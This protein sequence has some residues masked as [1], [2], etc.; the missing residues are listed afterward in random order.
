MVLLLL[1]LLVL[2]VGSG[3]W[4]LALGLRMPSVML[5]GWLVVFIAQTSVVTLVMGA[6]EHLSSGWL[7]VA[8]LVVALV[9]VG[10]A[11]GWRRAF[12]S[13]SAVS[14]GSG[15]RS[16]F[17]HSWRH[18]L[19]LIF[20]CTVLVAY[21][22][23]LYLGV[24][25]P[26]Y[27]YDANAYHLVS[28]D[29]WVMTGRLVDTPQNLYS[30]VY[31]KGQELLEA[32][33]AVFLRTMQYAVLAQ[34]FLV[35]LG[36]TSVFLLSRLVRARRSYAAMAA[37][38]FAAIPVVFLQ[39]GTEYVDV[40]A[41][42]TA[43]A[44]I[45]LVLAGYTLVRMN[46]D[47]P[48]AAIPERTYHGFVACLLLAGISA[49]MAASIKSS[50]LATD[51][52]ALLVALTCYWRL[53]NRREMPDIPYYLVSI[54]AL[55]AVPML[56]IASFWYF[57]TW[58]GYGSP[59]YPV[60]V[61][62]LPG[63]GT[64]NDI[65]IGGNL[66]DSLAHEPGGK[67]GQI[68]ASWATDLHRH[69]YSYDQRLGGFGIQWPVILLPALVV[70]GVAWL[71]R[72]DRLVWFGI[73]FTSLVILLVVG[74]GWWS[75]YTIFLPA[76][77]CAALA[78]VLERLARLR[79]PWRLAPTVI[80][81][82]FMAAATTSLWWAADPPAI[83]ALPGGPHAA[84]FKDAV[85]LTKLSAAAR[86]VS[87]YPWA[88]QTDLAAVPKGAAIGMFADDLAF[89]H[90]F[91][92]TDLRHEL[93]P[94]TKTSSASVLAREMRADN[95]RYVVFT[96]GT[97]VAYKQPVNSR[98]TTTVTADHQFHY[99]GLLGGVYGMYVYRLSP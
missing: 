74:G 3:A 8:S 34:V 88:I 12:V 37:L 60:I 4:I 50:A 55:F 87:V 23:I 36:S 53:A 93:V 62:G 43:F 71:R 21:G 94:I 90:P 77:G 91:V 26:A 81:L 96:E 10:W 82:A 70:A 20:G 5:T 58:V 27:S 44:T 45:C 39:A 24:R 63:K 54:I 76:A 33:P 64:F 11:V 95:L 18:P 72:R 83:I 40:G 68:I 42:A 32:F 30:N 47:G 29:M 16:A 2:L 67:I 56:A 9:E 7:G 85:N 66:P 17:A 75:R 79:L 97:G 15:L 35:A 51:G 28:P 80:V 49:G 1:T 52:I 22:W 65:I 78:Y 25:V 59:F 84:T 14:F 86:A 38:G 89:T 31:P 41:A 19:V 6:F 61:I 69:P 98:L 48:D 46:T 92:G 73:I 99:T 13:R 57:R